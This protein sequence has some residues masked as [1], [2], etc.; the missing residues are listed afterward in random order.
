M[1]TPSPGFVTRRSV[2][3]IAAPTSVVVHT[4]AESTDQPHRAWA[5]EAKASGRSD[6]GGAYPV[7]E[8]RMA[9]SSASTMGG[10][11]G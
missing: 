8:L 4:C 6:T 1:M 3:T 2:S 5:K 11:S 10:A 9:A 7:S